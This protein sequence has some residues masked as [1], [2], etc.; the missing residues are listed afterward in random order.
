MSKRTVV[1]IILDGWGIGR[2]D[3]SNPIF[4]ADLKNINQIKANFPSAGLQASGI[5]VGLPWGEE[6]NSEVGHLNI[7]GGKIIYQNYPKISLSIRDKS[8]F[9]NK[10]LR[11]VFERAKKKGSA[12]NLIGLLTDGNVHAS[13][14]HLLALIEFAE[15]E[16][17]RKINLHLITD[18]RDSPPNSAIEL[19]KKIP[20]SQNVV[21]STIGGRYYAMDRDKHWDRT[22]KYYQ[23]LIGEGAVA[24][25]CEIPIK[26]AY[27]KNLNDEYVF[28]AS[29]GP[30]KRSVQDGDSVIFFNFREDRMRQIVE[31]F[32][33]KNFDKF[34]VKNFTDIYVAAMTDY[35]DNFKIPVAFPKEQI[36]NPLSKILADNDKIQ[37]KISETEKYAHITYFF[38]GEIEPPFNNEYRVLI[39]SKGDIHYNEHPAMMAPEI[40]N[41]LIEA[42]EEQSYD[43]ILVNY[44]NSDVIAHTGNYQ[45]TLE[46]VKIIDGEIEKVMKAVLER[47]GAL[48][49]TSDHGNAERLFDPKTGEPETRHDPNPV[50]IYL[51]AKE[52]MRQND[53]E[54]IRDAEKIPIGVLADVAPTILEL[55]KIP[56]P[57][58]M[59]GQSLLKF[60]L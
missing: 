54:K 56:K 26:N 14:E 30:E 59:T 44:A 21:L 9:K 48:I 50:P 49:I 52:F 24:D 45:A 17:V 33:N 1:L 43:F 12:I 60:L 22:Q 34:P 37:L 38:N 5:A 4:T 10:V 25:N 58:E 29:L 8:F 31:P 51:I 6:G 28:P 32:I 46:A 36:E 20:L 47:D 18:G 3:Q 35:D 11:E 15:K 41:R 39:P 7:G 2:N 42:I 27:Q 53:E 19:L 23:T 40:T 57:K 13:L 55:M 16:Q